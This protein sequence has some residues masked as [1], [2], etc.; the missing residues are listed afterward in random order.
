MAVGFSNYQG[1]CF[2]VAHFAPIFVR[3]LLY[4]RE[5]CYGYITSVWNT[6]PILLEQPVSISQFCG[7]TLLDL[8]NT[9]E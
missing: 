1:S 8:D 2:C 9:R 5:T 7:A 3:G 6:Y 4:A